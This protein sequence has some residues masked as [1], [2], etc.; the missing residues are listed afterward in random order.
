[1]KLDASTWLHRFVLPLVAGGDV[2]VAGAI[3][4]AD[5]ELLLGHPFER[6]ESAARIAEARQ[7][8]MAEILID[9][10]EPPLD[11]AALK[12]AVAMQNLLFLGHPDTAGLTVRKSKLAR[13]ARFAEKLATLDAPATVDELAARHSILHH[14]FDLG[15]DDVRVSFWAGK[16]E[17]KGSEP[18]PRLLK[19]A[20]V[21][22]VREERW[23]VS[24][25]SEAVADPQQRAI[26][27][28]ML[29]ASPLTNLLEPLRLDPP[30][31]LRPHVRWL[32]EPLIARA[33]ADRYLSIGLAP[34]GP[35][36]TAALLRVLDN[37]HAVDDARIATAFVCHLHL[38]SLVGTRGQASFAELLSEMQTNAQTHPSV[39]DFYG[40]FAAAQRCGLGRPADVKRNRRL[41]QSI[42]AYSAACGAACGEPRVLELA[43]LMMRGVQATLALTASG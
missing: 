13:V 10:R 33:V 31:E 29:T 37:P 23:R 22:R 18:P 39:K 30:L 35:A 16:R 20:A 8:V 41:E 25:A 15:R 6:D 27:V 7:A 32:R 9:A 40:L 28:A 38:L 12:L 4:A 36:L 21:R 17:F 34:V 1:M 19:W 24:I 26:V 2:R 11:D 5:V 43:G 42:N 3:G 14:L